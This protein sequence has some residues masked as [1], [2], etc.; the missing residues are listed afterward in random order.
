[1]MQFKKSRIS[2]FS[3]AIYSSNIELNIII[4]VIIKL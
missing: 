3:N 4:V 1:M 2:M